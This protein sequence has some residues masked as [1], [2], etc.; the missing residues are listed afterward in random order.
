MCVGEK[1]LR[2]SD[3]RKRGRGIKRSSSLHIAWLLGWRV[4]GEHR[5]HLAMLVQGS[6][7]RTPLMSPCSFQH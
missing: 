4:P 5:L 3:K 6:E 7:G 2:V 1:C